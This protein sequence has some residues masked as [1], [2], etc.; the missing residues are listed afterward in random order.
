MDAIKEEPDS[1]SETDE[2][3]VNEA[4]EP[5]AFAAVKVEVKVEPQEVVEVKVEPDIE[6]GFQE[7]HA[8]VNAVRGTVENEARLMSITEGLLSMKHASC[9]LWRDCRA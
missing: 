7:Y 5:F 2:C 8:D 6:V 9:A 3:Q 4:T 1:K